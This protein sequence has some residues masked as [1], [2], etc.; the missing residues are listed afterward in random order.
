MPTR[1]AGNSKCRGL[2]C[3]SQET[4]SITGSNLGQAVSGV[5]LGY[6]A[7]GDVLLE[8][9]EQRAEQAVMLPEQPR[10]RDAPLCNKSASAS[11]LY[12]PDAPFMVMATRTHIPQY[13]EPGSRVRQ[14]PLGMYP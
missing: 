4:F 7:L 2:S 8:R 11:S 10:L 5:L 14:G 1:Q 13:T 3:S 12:F 9:R 6:V